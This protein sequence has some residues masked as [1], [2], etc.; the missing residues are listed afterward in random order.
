MLSSGTICLMIAIAIPGC[1]HVCLSGKAGRKSGM[2]FGGSCMPSI[3][4]IFLG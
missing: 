4:L 2:C 1:A 3:R